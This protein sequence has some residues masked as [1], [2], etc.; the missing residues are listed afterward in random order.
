MA[1]EFS[2]PKG[3]KTVPREGDR[4]SRGGTG[5]TARGGECT[6]RVQKRRHG[7]RT[8]VAPHGRWLRWR[9]LISP[10]EAGS[11]ATRSPQNGRSPLDARRNGCPA[12]AW[13]HRRIA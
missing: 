2:R 7:K 9:L 4:R 12:G 3:R 11:R 13:R 6:A 10:D 1:D 5:A 8:S